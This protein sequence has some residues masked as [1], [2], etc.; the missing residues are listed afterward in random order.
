M[1]ASAKFKRIKIVTYDR[2][3]FLLWQPE[4]I[5]V[6]FK[7]SIF[8]REF[9]KIGYGV[10]IEVPNMILEKLTPVKDVSQVSALL[11]DAATKSVL[12]SL[13]GCNGVCR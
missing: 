6:R 9:D 4:V 1:R 5:M 2:I 11:R 7:Q 13:R 10:L 8:F 3:V 12:Q